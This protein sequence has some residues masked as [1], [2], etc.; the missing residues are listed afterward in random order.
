LE[1]GHGVDQGADGD[2]HVEHR[3]HDRRTLV[4]EVIVDGER[5]RAAW[6]GL[7]DYLV[8]P[9]GVA[10]QLVDAAAYLLAGGDFSL[11]VA[12]LTDAKRG[13]DRAT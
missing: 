2:V 6:V 3:F 4:R 11:V 8:R 10:L 12:V 7:A 13:T 5:E 9:L 1:I